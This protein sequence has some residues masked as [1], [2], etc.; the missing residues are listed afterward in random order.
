MIIAANWKMNCLKK[1]A[2]ILVNE[3]IKAENFFKTPKGK[4]RQTWKSSETN[5]SPSTRKRFFGKPHI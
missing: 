5:S 2:N 4:Q 1:E 3:L